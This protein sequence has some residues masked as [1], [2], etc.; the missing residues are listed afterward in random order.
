VYIGWKCRS[1]RLNTLGKQLQVVYQVFGRD[2]DWIDHVG[3][4]VFRVGK[5]KG[6]VAHFVRSIWAHP[7]FCGRRKLR[8]DLGGI[9]SLHSNILTAARQ[10]TSGE[11][12]RTLSPASI[13]R[14]VK[15]LLIDCWLELLELIQKLGM[16]SRRRCFLPGP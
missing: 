1:V 6:R 15:L 9:V 12:A 14:Q 11:P 13:R 3:E 5:H 8:R 4:I 7:G 2:A 10:N 16:V